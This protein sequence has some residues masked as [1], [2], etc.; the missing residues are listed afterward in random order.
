MAL[1]LGNIPV[2]ATPSEAEQ[3][4]IREAIGINDNIGTSTAAALARKAAKGGLVFD[5][6][7]GTSASIITLADPNDAFALDGKVQ[8]FYF[9]ITGS[10]NVSN[11]G[12]LS[13]RSSNVGGYECVLTS[14]G[15]IVFVAY[16]TGTNTPFLSNKTTATGLND[17]TANIIKVIADFTDPSTA[18][19]VFYVNGVLTTTVVTTAPTGTYGDATSGRGLSLGYTVG[20]GKLVGKLSDFT[21]F[22]TAL[23]AAQALEIYNAGSA[24]AWL[25]EN[26]EYMWGGEVNTLSTAVNDATNAYETFSGA[27]DSAFSAANTDSGFDF[28]YFPLGTTSG[29]GD[30]WLVTGTLT[31]NSGTGVR[32]ALRNT[33]GIASYIVDVSAS[34]AFAVYLTGVASGGTR[35]AFMTPT[36]SGNVDFSVSGVNMVSAGA[37]AHLPLTDD[38]RQLR[39]ISPNRYDAIASA[40]GVNHLKQKDTHVF[41][42]DSAT[43]T[44]SPYLIAASDILAPNEVVTGVTV[45][46]RYYAAS[47]AQT[48]SYRRIQLVI[49][50]SNIDVKR[51]NGTSVETIASTTPTSTTDFDIAV[52]TQRI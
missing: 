24:E 21:P 22:N 43:G 26:P 32:V 41:R 52:L 29:V 48:D 14:V 2:Y 40:T 30:Y 42:A 31:L 51:S 50:A 13:R 25:A 23:T 45:D 27:T 49:N 38:C 6:T 12:V 15:E 20:F 47:G 8:S 46:G 44:G 35:L 3:A 18:E 10:N 17:G 7:A 36:G 39:D 33:I 19:I 34:G 16:Q 11:N 37:L 9:E 1:D 5:G 4:Q 28:A